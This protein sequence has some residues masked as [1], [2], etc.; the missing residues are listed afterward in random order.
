MHSTE[1]PRTPREGDTAASAGHAEGAGYARALLDRIGAGTS[2]PD[3]LA[4]LM[5]A[6]HSGALLHG[7]AAVIFDAL[8]RVARHGPTT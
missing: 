6:L 2:N 4:A 1:S 7:F 8:R 3:D 5:Q